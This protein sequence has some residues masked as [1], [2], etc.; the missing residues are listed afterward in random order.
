MN[1]N[2]SKKKKKNHRPDKSKK[3]GRQRLI[4][5]CVFHPLDNNLLISYGIDHLT[6]WS[7]RSDGFFERSDVAV[8][9]RVIACVAFLDSGDLVAGDRDGMVST[10]SVSNEGEY[11][12]SHEFEAHTAGD[13]VNSIV[14]LNDTTMVTGGEKDRKLVAW[15]PIREY[16]KMAEAELPESMGAPRA[17]QPQRQGQKSGDTR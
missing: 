11:Y 14:V 2:F 10:Y 13:G 15:D 9:G 3:R 12:M 4:N 5:G 7:R 8:K 1:N 16:E 17:I 6:F